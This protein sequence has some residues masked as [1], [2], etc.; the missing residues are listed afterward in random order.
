MKHVSPPGAIWPGVLFAAFLAAFGVSWLNPA[1]QFSLST[2]YQIL[3]ALAPENAWGVFAVAFSAAWAI[4]LANGRPTHRIVVSALGGLLLS[5]LAAAIFVGNTLSTWALP[6]LVI[7]AGAVYNAA[8]MWAIWT[9][10]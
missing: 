7:G 8:R 9:Q 5:F 3:F 4:I 1:E 6:T 2:N 10:R